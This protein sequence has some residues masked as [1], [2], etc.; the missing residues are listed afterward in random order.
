MTLVQLTYTS[1]FDWFSC[2]APVIRY[3]LISRFYFVTGPLDYRQMAQQLELFTGGISADFEVAAGLNDL[4]SVQAGYCISMTFASNG[5]VC[6]NM[7]CTP[8]DR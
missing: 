6:R 1:T 2:T 4:E 8:R 3:V 7:L 5:V